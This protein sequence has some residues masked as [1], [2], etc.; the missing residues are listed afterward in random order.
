ML[1]IFIIFITEIVHK[2]HI[3]TGNQDVLT[4]TLISSSS[5][6]RDRS[7]SLDCTE[8]LFLSETSS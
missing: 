7:V 4:L 8:V 1:I 3:Y 6:S 5:S 2:V